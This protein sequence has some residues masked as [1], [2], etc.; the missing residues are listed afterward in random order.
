MN[1]VKAMLKRHVLNFHVK[2]STE[3]LSD[4]PVNNS[5]NEDHDTERRSWHESWF[6]QRAELEDIEFWK[7]YTDQY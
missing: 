4:H 7:V 2:I 1:Y 5:T 3:K 6:S